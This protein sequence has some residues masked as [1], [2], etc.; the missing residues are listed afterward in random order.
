MYPHTHTYT[1]HAPSPPS[2]PSCHAPV[3]SLKHNNIQSNILNS[4]SAQEKHLAPLWSPRGLWS[5]KNSN[6]NLH[7]DVAFGFV[8]GWHINVHH[9]IWRPQWQWELGRADGRLRSEWGAWCGRGAKPCMSSI[10]ALPLCPGFSGRLQANTPSP[11]PGGDG[12]PS[13][14]LLSP[15]M[16][17][18]NVFSLRK[19]SLVPHV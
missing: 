8:N 5:G 16:L 18:A 17:W 11:Q 14:S 19:P 10:P 3:C 9:D 15:G 1:H 12:P 6:H 7:L 2:P 13:A 4:L